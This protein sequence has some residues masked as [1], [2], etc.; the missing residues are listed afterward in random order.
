M[1]LVEVKMNE[2]GSG[3]YYKNIGMIR[4]NLRIGMLMG[5]C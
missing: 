3:I 5:F 2:R 1:Q 4:E